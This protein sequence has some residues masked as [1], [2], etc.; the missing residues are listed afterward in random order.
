MTENGIDITGSFLDHWHSHTI[1][2]SN[3]VN[4]RPVYFYKDVTDFTV[5]T[6]AGQVI[7][8]SCIRVIVENQ[9]F[10]NGSVGILVVHSSY[11]TIANNTCNNNQ[12]GI[13]LV[14]SSSFTIKSNTCNN[15]D[16]GIYLSGSDVST[17]SHNTCNNNDY[18]I[19][20]SSYS[21]RSTLSNNLCKN[22]DYGIYLLYSDVC[23]LSSNTISKN[24]VGI[25]LNFSS[26]NKAQYNN[27]YNN[28]E[29]GIRGS[30]IAT[31]N[32]WGATNGPCHSSKNPE[33][34]GDNITGNVIFSPWIDEHGNLHYL[35]DENNNDVDP[36]GRNILLVIIGL[37]FV[38]LVFVI[39]LPAERF[40]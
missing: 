6:G 26:G 34:K 2:A 39:R 24:S 11:I 4:G 22:N 36:L 27:I 13:R 7:L 32:Y 5:P 21:D 40:K 3:T 38:S 16:Y 20:L 19:Y 17:I 31:N 29:Y 37:I 35:K 8:A 15:N 10:N 1:A 30:I 23:M 9:H 14:A 28:T 25:N 18:G 33:G 12:V